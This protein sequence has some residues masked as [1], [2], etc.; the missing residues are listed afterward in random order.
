MRRLEPEEPDRASVKKP[1]A[2]REQR[3]APVKAAPVQPVKAVRSQPAKAARGQ[4]AKAPP[5]EGVPHISCHA[6]WHRMYLH[7]EMHAFQSLAD[8]GLAELP[9]A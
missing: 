9:G 7:P 6:E 1:K 4:P 5:P 2:S 3:V 8:P